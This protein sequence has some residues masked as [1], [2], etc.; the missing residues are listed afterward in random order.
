MIARKTAWMN[1]S[2]DVLRDAYGVY[3]DYSCFFVF[4]RVYSWLEGVAQSTTREESNPHYLV[5]P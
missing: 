1:P 5:G 2:R 3:S 4:F